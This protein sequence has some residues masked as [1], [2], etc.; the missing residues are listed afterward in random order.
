MGFEKK[1]ITML[2]QSKLKKKPYHRISD[3]YNVLKLRSRNNLKNLILYNVLEL[4][5]DSW[6]LLKTSSGSAIF[7]FKVFFFK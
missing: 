3:V 6:I 1:F 2:V 5:G 4:T 7:N